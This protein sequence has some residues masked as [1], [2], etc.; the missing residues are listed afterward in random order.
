MDSLKRKCE[1]IMKLNILEIKDLLL[2]Q[3]FAVLASQLL[4]ESFHVRANVIE[5]VKHLSLP[6]V[7]W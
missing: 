2:K 7:K 3:H 4:H 6:Y 1:Q 5:V